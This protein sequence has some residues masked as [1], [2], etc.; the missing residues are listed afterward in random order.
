MFIEQTIIYATRIFVINY[1]FKFHLEQA[2]C[3]VEKA[4]SII[5]FS[6]EFNEK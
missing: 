1:N 3:N 4:T 6:F 2:A 5:I